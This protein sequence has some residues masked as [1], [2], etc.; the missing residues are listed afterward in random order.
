MHIPFIPRE[1]NDWR[2]SQ[3]IRIRPSIRVKV[4]IDKQ[5]IQTPATDLYS[6]R[7]NFKIS[8]KISVIRFTR[9]KTD[10][11]NELANGDKL[12]DGKKKVLGKPIKDCEPILVEVNGKTLWEY[13][14]EIFT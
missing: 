10:K 9:W 6:W 3:F 12:H 7:Q 8:I 2:I 4:I 11:L 5:Q 14:D 1:R 13:N